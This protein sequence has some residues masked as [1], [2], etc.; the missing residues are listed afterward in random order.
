MLTQRKMQGSERM[1]WLLLSRNIYENRFPEMDLCWKENYFSGVRTI[2]S[3]LRR[4][5]T[6]DDSSG[7]ANHWHYCNETDLVMTRNFLCNDLVMTLQRNPINDFLCNVNPFLEICSQKYF[8]RVLTNAT[9]LDPVIYVAPKLMSSGGI[10]C[11]IIFSYVCY[12]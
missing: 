5:G 3:D 10:I 9:T 11:G 1:H 4:T 6:V 12:N 2:F 8:G 7:D